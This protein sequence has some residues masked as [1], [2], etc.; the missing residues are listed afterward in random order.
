VSVDFPTR[1]PISRARLLLQK[2]EECSPSERDYHETLLE[3]AIV[4]SRAAISRLQKKFRDHPEWQSW[5]A[6]LLDH[7]SV[8][9]IRTERDFILKEAPPRIGQRII[10]GPAPLAKELYYYESPDTPAVDTV[11]RHTEA[12]AQ[13]VLEAEK[14]FG[15]E[16]P[17]VT[18][19]HCGKV[20]AARQQTVGQVAAAEDYESCLRKC[21]P[22]GLGFSNAF[23]ANI[24]RLTII[25][26]NPFASLPLYLAEGHESVLANSFN[27][28]NRA[29]KAKYFTFSTSE[30]HLT[31]T[32]FRYLQLEKKLC[33][34]PA[35]LGL[36]IMANDE[37]TMLLWGSPVPWDDVPGGQIRSKLGS[38]SDKLT[39][40][41]AQR[42][43]PDVILDFGVAGV[44]V[45][46]VKHRSP[47]DQQNA[48]YANWARY[49]N[50]PK[51]FQSGDEARRSG[52]YE[53]AR[54]WRFAF[55]LADGRPF[56]VVNL[57][58]EWLF[59]GEHG[60]RLDAFV[61]TLRQSKH[62]R[63]VTAT[64]QKF[65]VGFEILPWLKSY[66]VER[67]VDGLQ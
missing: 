24:K 60:R 50:E 49:I 23:T 58:P 41:A 21:E 37:P 30:D 13:L 26:R 4:F 38:I 19:P 31:W 51:A 63:F 48:D 11:R 46:E 39:E 45:I 35:N 33:R 42:S 47:N 27:E 18:C 36:A 15:K 53:L 55:E 43:E 52:L 25:H 12:T 61:K 44:V 9:F 59:T 22:C 54:N 8:Q 29:S 6:S 20:V 34:A 16:L 57:G 7:E 1:H 3:A 14:K 17:T 64:W 67:Q 2:A 28:T 5:F 62:N 10:M 56:A 40:K 65:L 66:L 32:V